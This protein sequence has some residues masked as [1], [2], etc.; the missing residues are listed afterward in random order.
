M[1]LITDPGPVA[2]GLAERVAVTAQSRAFRP[3]RRPLRRRNGRHVCEMPL[4]VHG[5]AQAVP[6]NWDRFRKFLIVE[7]RQA[8]DAGGVGRGGVTTEGGGHAVQHRF[9]LIDSEAFNLPDDLMLAGRGVHDVVGL[10]QD[11]AF[12]NPLEPDIA[13]IIKI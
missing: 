2:F 9:G 12:E 7:A 5:V 4:Q 10:G 6:S 13:V 11:R 1:K 8:Q 3:G